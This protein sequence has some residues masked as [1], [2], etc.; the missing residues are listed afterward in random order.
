MSGVSLKSFSL[1]DSEG[2]FSATNPKYNTEK[3][4]YISYKENTIC[5][6]QN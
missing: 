2:G 6:G 3:K 1:L 5:K 4:E